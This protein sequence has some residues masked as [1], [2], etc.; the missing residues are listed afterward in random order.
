MLQVT[1]IEQAKE[2]VHISKRT[3]NDPVTTGKTHTRQQFPGKSGFDSRQRTWK[4]AWGVT[5]LTH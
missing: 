4:R 5:W 3:V 2:D 1:E